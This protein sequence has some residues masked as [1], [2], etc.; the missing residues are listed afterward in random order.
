MLRRWAALYSQPTEAE[1]AIEPAIASLG[2]PYRFNHPLWALRCFPDFVLP[3]HRVVIEVDDSSHARAAKR[4]ADEERTQKLNGA[5]WS[6]VR[7]WNDEALADP[8]GTV[9]R[10]MAAAGLDLKTRRPA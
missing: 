2:V 4:K 3:Q 9:D 10:L 1:R 8:Y 7:C 5:G 6:V